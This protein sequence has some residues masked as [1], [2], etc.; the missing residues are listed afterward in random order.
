MS[1]N[2]ELVLMVP[3]KKRKQI[4]IL[5]SS[6]SQEK[7][8]TGK[9]MW[10]DPDVLSCISTYFRIW[11]VQFELLLAELAAHLKR[12]RNHFRKLN[13]L[14]E[15]L[16]MCL[17]YY[18]FTFTIS[19]YIQYGCLFWATSTLVAKCSTVIGHICLF[20]SEKSNSFINN[21]CC[22]FVQR[23]FVV[24]MNDCIKKIGES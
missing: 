5:G 12:Q 4:E 23:N 14:E 15:C 16:A 2:D 9:I 7:A 11:V 10:L 22:K 18:Y 13:D 20:G 17:G 24:G 8:A 19:M 3:N 1:S 21:K 6:N